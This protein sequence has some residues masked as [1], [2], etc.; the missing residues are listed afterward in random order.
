MVVYEL[1]WRD[2]EGGSHFI[3]ILPERRKDPGRMTQES[4]INWGKMA[5]GGEGDPNSI[6]FVQIEI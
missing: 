2:E 4:I 3:G 1:Y 6:Y 5:I